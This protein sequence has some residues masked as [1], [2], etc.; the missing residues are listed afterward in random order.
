MMIDILSAFGVVLF[1]LFLAYLAACAGAGRFL[2]P[3][4]W[5]FLKGQK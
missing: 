5:L 1:I 4:D 2:D 3:V